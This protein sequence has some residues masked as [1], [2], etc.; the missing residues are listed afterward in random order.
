MGGVPLPRLTNCCTKS[1]NMSSKFPI[2]MG[3]NR[4]CCAVLCLVTPVVS[5]S[6]RPLDCSPPGSSVLEESSRQ[7]CWSGLPYPPPGDLSNP[8]IEPYRQCLLHDRQV[9]YLLNHLGSPLLLLLLLSCFNHVRLC[10]TAQ[11]AVHQA[12][13]S[14]GFSRQEYW[15]GLPFPSPT[16]ESEK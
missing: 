1:T 16:H 14:L 10:T 3:I 7:E 12:P 13:P 2:C 5:D 15:G 9:L 11:T 6:L 8:G 4:Q